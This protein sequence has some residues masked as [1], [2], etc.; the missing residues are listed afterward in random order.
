MNKSNFFLSLENCGF[1]TKNTNLMDSNGEFKETY[2]TKRDV[3]LIVTTKGN[4]VLW[5][6]I[7]Y[8]DKNDS[9][10]TIFSNEND[11]KDWLYKFSGA[12]N[13]SG[14]FN[15]YSKMFHKSVIK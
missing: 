12:F 6:T 3:Q 10:S 8:S 15:T 13:E 2:F 5:D 4:D 11:V 7:V 9:G 1:Q 14:V